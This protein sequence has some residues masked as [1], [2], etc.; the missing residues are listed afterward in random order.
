MG[1]AQGGQV[2]LDESIRGSGLTFAVTG[3][4]GWLG[5]A[6][7]EVIA[8]ALGPDGAVRL[9]AFASRARGEALDSGQPL[10]VH[11]LHDLPDCPADVLLHF[12][13]VTREFAAERGVEQYVLANLAIS[14]TVLDFI[15]MRRPGFVAYASSGAA[16]AAL[17]RGPLD[18]TADP[19]GA[20]KVMDELALRRATA[21]AGGR[22]LVVRV[23]NVSG[24][25]LTKPSAFALS[26]IIGQVHAGGPVR[27]RASHPVV[28]SYV[29]VEDLVS[30]M[31]A[32][33]LDRSRGAD[34]QVDTAGEVQ[35]EVGDLADAIRRVLG[36]PDVAVERQF[37][38]AAEPDR[39]AGAEGQFASLAGGL[40]IPLRDL[41]AQIARTAQG[42]GVPVANHT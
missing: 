5:R 10:A 17:A 20:L 35:V 21:D 25:W 4:T 22:S 26:D 3:A 30:V 39:Y 19:Y 13:Y 37:D 2:G 31:I 24:P 6:A 40:G 8:R 11:A 38:P 15:R 23:F 33:A 27:I 18:I 42:M 1:R 9:V 36:R 34:V 28:R 32:A 41:D 29:D 14:G 7:C 16:A 12:A